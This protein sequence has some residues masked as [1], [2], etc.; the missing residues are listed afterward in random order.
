[1]TSQNE[2]EAGTLNPGSKKALEK[3]CTCPVKDNYYGKGVPMQNSDSVYWVNSGCP[4]HYR[5]NS[6]QLKV[7]FRRK[8]KYEKAVQVS[9]RERR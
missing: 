9:T 4:L 7:V 1:M 2:D 3:G 6:K 5:K 8:G